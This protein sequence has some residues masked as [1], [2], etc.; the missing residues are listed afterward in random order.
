MIPLFPLSTI[1]FPAGVLTLRVFEV[2]Y[3]DM[4][5]KCIADGT[6]FG[7]VALLS[8]GEVRTPEGK[9]EFA[10][11]GTM[12]QIVEWTAPM[13]ALI[14]IRCTGTS[15]FM[16]AGREL[17]K[18][19]LWQGEAK[20][21]L[22]DAAVP[23]PQKLQACANALGKLVARLQKEKVPE[24]EMPISRPFRLDESGWVADRWCELLPM[25]LERK[26]ELLALQDPVGRLEVVHRMLA[27]RDVL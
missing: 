21:L 15:R 10:S 19:G 9:E 22:D 17:G 14:H 8:G 16:L 27:D 20:P 13:P 26:L 4:I 23:I 5:K 7:V 25:P 2:R 11:V 6:Q 3:L 12:A 24:A 1:L 18:Y